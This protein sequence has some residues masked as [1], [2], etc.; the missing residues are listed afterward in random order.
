MTTQTWFD[1]TADLRDGLGERQEGHEPAVWLKI[2]GDWTNRSHTDALTLGSQTYTF[3]TSYNQDTSAIL[4]GVDLLNVTD[5][6]KAFVLGLEGGEA[7]SDIRFKGTPDRYTLSGGDFGGYVTY[8]SGGLFIDGTI[9]ANFMKLQGNLPGIN[10]N[11]ATTQP[12]LIAGRVNVV[13]GQLEAGYQMPIGGTWF[14]EPTGLLTYSRASFDQMGVPATGGGSLS[15][16]NAR[17]FQG[18]LGVRVGGEQ[19]F[20]YYRVKLALDARVWDEFEG[21]TNA[22][23]AVPAGPNFGWSNSIKGVFGEVQGEANLFTTT[24]GL[25]A[26]LNGGWKFKS[27]YSEGTI[28]LGARYQW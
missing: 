18:A 25:S 26:F 13:G 21:T 9:N 23:L 1:R 14:W 17:S 4:G 15:L 16:S 22:Q 10:G 8:L 20:Q 24:S 7:N 11:P 3:N 5:K 27:N 28:T 19:T 6:S 12:T 2:V